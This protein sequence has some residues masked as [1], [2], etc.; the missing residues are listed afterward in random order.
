MSSGQTDLRLKYGLNPQQAE[1]VAATT[2]G[3]PLPFTV[4]SGT[5][6]T[7]NLL[8][9]LQ[10]WQLVR[11]ADAALG[12][13]AAASIKHVSP[14]GAAVAGETDA[15]T[16]ATFGLEDEPSAVAGAYARARDCD[17]RSSYGDLVAVSDTVDMATARLLARVVSDGI[18]A[19]DFEPGVVS[20]LA[21]KKR[22]AFL[23]LRMDPG[24]KPPGTEVRDVFGVRITQ[25]ADPLVL[26][27]QVLGE[28]G[29][30]SEEQRRDAVLGLIAARYAQSNSVTYVAGGA[31]IGIGTGQQSRVDCVRLAGEKADRWRLRR[32]PRV[33]ATRFPDGMPLQERVNWVMRLVEGGLSPRES[34]AL[35]RFPGP[36]RALGA[37]EKRDWLPGKTP[38]VLASDAYLPFRDNVDV[39]ARH[40]VRGIVEG[41]GSRRSEDVET[42]CEEHGI[43]LVRTGLRLFHH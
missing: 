32:H 37:E 33:A 24:H 15:V 27:E 11:A 43:A 42:A 38:C 2:D 16:R 1:A 3:G 18:I 19:P 9:A 12:L 20:V 21:R 25:D 29:V 26:D 23:V 6:S 40:G 22:G 36:V 10:G 14:A 30:M 5:P 34:A 8:D 28:A 35:A 17:P 7:L 13:P 31:T 41:G 4:L 39:A